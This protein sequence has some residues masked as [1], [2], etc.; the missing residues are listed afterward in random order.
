M[1][2]LDMGILLYPEKSSGFKRL[3]RKMGE[4]GDSKR[5]FYHTWPFDGL[6]L[7]IL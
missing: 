5:V 6:F 2:D 3:I 7:I 4:H 1:G